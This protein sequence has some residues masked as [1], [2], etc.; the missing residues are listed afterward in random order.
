[1]ALVLVLQVVEVVELAEAKINQRLFQ[2][3][4]HENNL[5]SLSTP[6]HDEKPMQTFFCWSHERVAYTNNVTY[7]F[8]NTTRV[9]AVKK[10]RINYFA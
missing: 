1:M 10:L 5:L 3:W 7:G 9:V 4:L 8:Y 6:F 2:A